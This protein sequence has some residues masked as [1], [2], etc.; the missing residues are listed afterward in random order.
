MPWAAFVAAAAGFASGVRAD[1]LTNVWSLPVD[2]TRTY[3]TA[4]NTERGL[5]INPVSSNVL[6]L[7]RQGTPA[8]YV[9]SPEDGS[10]GTET[11]GAP[12]TLRRTNEAE[13]DIIAGG[14][15]AL[16]LVG[17]AEDGAVY[18]ANLTAPTAVTNVLFK[19]YRWGND[20]TE[21][22]VPVS[23]AYEGNPLEG[24][25]DPGTGQ[26]IRFGDN[27][28]VRGKGL[29]T[30]LAAT[31][32]NGKYLV[33]FTTTDGV[34]FT[35][36]T[37]TTDFSGQAGLGTTFGADNTVWVK[38]NGAPLRR[39]QFNL[40]AGTAA[41]LNTIPTTI[42]G[43]NVTGIGYDPVTRR[44]AGI[45]Y[46]AHT[47]AAY[48]LGDPTAPVPL[49]DPVAFPGDGFA[50]ISNANGT[51]AAGLSGDRIAALDSNNGVLYL[52][53]VPA[54]APEPPVITTPPANL[55]VYAGGDA[56]FSVAVQGTPPFAY[57]WQREGTNLAG[58]TS[59]Q[60]LLL[61][62]STNQA[63]AYAVV[64]S[65]AAG[66]VTSTQAVLTVRTPLS[67]GVLTPLWSATPGTL[68]FLTTDNT[69]RGL[70]WNPATSNL[71][72]ASRSP[73]NLVAVLDAGT[74]ALKH[75]LKTTDAEGTPVITGGTLALNMIG[76]AD[77]GAVYA[78]NLITDS[79]AAT[80]LL[81]K[82]ADD[83]PDTVPAP[84]LISGLETVA[85][86]WGDTL[87]VR[88]AGAGTQILLGARGS[89]PQEGRKFALLTTTDGAGFTAQVFTVA[90]VAATAFG[91]G[92]AFGPGDT[93]FGTAGGQPLVHVAFNT[94]TG[95][96][97]LARS[98]A[99][100]NVPFAVGFHAVHVASNLL[101]GVA[102]ET[103]DNVQL[104][105][106]ADLDAP[107]LLDQELI[108][109][110]QANPNGTG[111]A[112]FGGD[113][114]FVL[115][116]N[117]G[118]RAYRLQAGGTPGGPATLGSPQVTGGQFSFQLTGTAGASYEMQRTTDFASWSRVGDFTAPATITEAVGAAP[119][120]Y[121]AVAR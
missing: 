58:A 28:A 54:E 1:T 11:L 29:D 9:L 93:V 62:V 67:T 47:L 51:G 39:V 40:A 2:G 5:A 35:N 118:L 121:R 43:A 14:T 30:Q 23:L 36:R 87:D 64:V 86:R 52:R 115:N 82:W 80:F 78:G 10:D 101:A 18:A 24:I 107:V 88:G 42:I 20:D 12:R 6:V 120:F 77:D 44:F 84:L 100:T 95:E 114:L 91:L 7:S 85:E 22:S 96:A 92:I 46:V 70:A 83:G 48:D 117:H 13:E 112:D 66:S 94:G 106:L 38:A 111:S 81:Y 97:T 116:T 3:I 113:K 25:T 71:L 15:F 104:Y 61:G 16:N 17:A 74:G 79:S 57:Q 34:T 32:R 119:A 31:S 73:S 4:S 75:Y 68:P 59:A 19:I 37:F 41:T 63:G 72:V 8:V 56:T 33:I 55:T 45:D 50:N 89:A 76:V 65:N 105:G 27:F 69:Q 109:P 49:G 110:E 21:T 98:Y 90:D 108:L 60:L 26:D 53:V 103:P 99:S 102:F